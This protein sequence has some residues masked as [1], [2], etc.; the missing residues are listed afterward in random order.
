MN[1][2]IKFRG[3]DEQ[4]RW[5]FGDLRHTMMV[6]GKPH[7]CI[8]NVDKDD[9][10]R[11]QEIW[12]DRI[13]EATIGQFTG[14]IDTNKKPI[15]EGDIVDTGYIL[16]DPW[17]DAAEIIEPMRCVVVYEDY[18]FRFQKG[19]DLSYL[20]HDITNLKVVGNIH[21]NPELMEGDAK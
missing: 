15:Y 17:D 19:E 21:D 16:Y 2:E 14:F 13:D 11:L 8:V 10:D 4:G 5:W 7:C 6:Y 9:Y 3:K 12:S 1:R 20:I 18:A